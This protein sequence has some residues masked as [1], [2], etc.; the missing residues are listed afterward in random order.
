MNLTSTFEVFTMEVPPQNLQ[1][2]DSRQHYNNNT[3]LLGNIIITN[4]QHHT[5]QHNKKDYCYTKRVI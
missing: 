2:L 4:K 5:E 1:S 3:I